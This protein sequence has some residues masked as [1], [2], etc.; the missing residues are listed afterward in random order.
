[1][2]KQE[3]K[4][5]GRLLKRAYEEIEEDALKRGINPLSTE[6]DLI[7]ADVRERMLLKLGYSLEEYREAKSEV[8]KER[9]IELSKDTAESL[10]W[11]FQSR[12]DNVE[13]K[14][15]PTK[16]DIA[17]IAREVAKE[18]I[19]APEII[20]KIV[21]EV[22]IREPQII[23][24]TTVEK[25]IEEVAYNE[26]PLREKIDSVS[27]RLDELKIPK[28]VDLEKLKEETKNTFSDM[29]EYNINILGMPNFRKLA[30]GIQGQ[31]DSLQSQLNRNIT[32]AGYQVPTG[33]V[34]GSNQTF[35]FPV[36]P[37]VIIVDGLTLRKTQTD[38]TANW[39][40]TTSIVL[41]I[42]PTME[43]YGIA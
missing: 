31:I 37:N 7:I 2:T 24:E 30:M 13:N 22:Q 35:V 42:A 15:I 21:K 36:A 3:F 10:L 11:D 17:V 12:I 28:E 25:V 32:Y 34:N 41:A 40:G 4:K 26:A 33:S 19:K 18:Y 20:N 8:E 5:V 16:Q 1:M 23:K 27:K 9:R 39:T 6:Y 38:G 43:C 29:F 14:Y